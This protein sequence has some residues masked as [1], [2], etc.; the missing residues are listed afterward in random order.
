MVFWIYLLKQADKF[1]HEADVISKLLRLFDGHRNRADAFT[2]EIGTI[3]QSKYKIH[4]YF[5]KHQYTSIQQTKA[6]SIH[7]SS[8]AF[9]VAVPLMWNYGWHNLLQLNIRLLWYFTRLHVRR[10]R[11]CHRLAQMYMWTCK[12]TNYRDDEQP[13]KSCNIVQK[14]SLVSVGQYLCR[15]IDHYLPWISRNLKNYRSNQIF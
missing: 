1:L 3:L 14:V 9:P 13:Y 4:P 15:I 5:T 11:H 6:Q 12:F 7:F 8:R 2:D 10:T